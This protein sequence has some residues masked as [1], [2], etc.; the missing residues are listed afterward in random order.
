MTNQKQDVNPN[1]D[2]VRK[3]APV[4]L[5]M[6][7]AALGLTVREIADVAGVS[8]DTITRLEGGQELKASTHLQIRQRI[9][10]AGVE[11]TNGERPGVRMRKKE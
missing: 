10:A 2:K 11:F 4:Q 8:H 7:R 5:K 1:L 3:L 6:A 9:E